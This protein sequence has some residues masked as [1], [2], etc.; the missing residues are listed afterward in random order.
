MA[1]NDFVQGFRGSKE[2]ISGLLAF[3]LFDHTVLRVQGFVLKSDKNVD[4]KPL[5]ASPALQVSS[6]TIVS[7]AMQQ[8]NMTLISQVVGLDINQAEIVHLITG[9]FAGK[10]VAT[11]LIEANL[12]NLAK[13]SNCSFKLEYGWRNL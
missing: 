8:G 5:F 7:E 1:S 10:G 4:R 12:A 9:K 2:N 6:T 13:D 11:K 3:P